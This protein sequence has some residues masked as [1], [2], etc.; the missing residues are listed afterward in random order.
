M[1]SW[2]GA[3]QLAVPC[4]V[5]V[6]L[7]HYGPR[8]VGRRVEVVARIRTFVEQIGKQ[9][10]TPA[11]LSVHRLGV[12]VEQQLAGVAAQAARRV[13][14][15]VHPKAVALAG[16]H[17]RQIAVPAVAGNLRQAQPCLAAALVEQAEV[18]PLGY[19]REQ[20]EVRTGAV[21]ARAQRVRPA[22]IHLDGAAARPARW[23]S[24]CHAAN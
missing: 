19:L 2:G 22:G 17:A 16:I 9:R 18:H 14:G 10:L 8:Y 20:R 23:G 4:P 12:R 3:I 6:G 7:V 24:G 1:V 11:K 15:T 5:E 21:E 13:E